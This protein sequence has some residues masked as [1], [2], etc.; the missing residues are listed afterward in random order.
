VAPSVS[1]S[2]FP[3]NL[4]SGDDFYITSQNL[5]VMETTND[6]FNS[7]LYELYVT[8]ETVPYW[9]R[10]I[11]ANRMATSGAE[12]S[13]LFTLYN[14]G[15]YNNQWQIVDNKLFTPGQPLQPNTLWIAEQIP[16]F[17][18]SAY[19]TSVLISQGYFPSYNVPYFPFIYNI[20][21][22]PAQEKAYGPMFSYNSCARANI[23]RRDQHNV[24]DVPTL[25]KMMRYNQYQTDPLSLQDA[26]RGI[27]ARC[28]LNA[29]WVSGT[30][31]TYGAF[32][33]IDNK[34]TTSAMSPQ[35][36]ALAVCGP[37]WDAQ[38]PFAWTEQWQYVPH[39]GMPQVFAFEYD[40]MTPF[41][42]TST[43]S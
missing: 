21:G 14:S 15:T 7:T 9:I 2:S 38:P 3:S 30:M 18:V 4:V 37:T 11:V 24:V 33:G 1:F 27:S 36:E 35:R 13:K 8:P 19:I 41:Q 43:D 34:L 22:Y 20:S 29:P 10:V 26:C 25:Q 16:G 39:Y 31:N 12:W 28:D 5:V 17:V 32:G 6:V 40:T 42:V 23:F